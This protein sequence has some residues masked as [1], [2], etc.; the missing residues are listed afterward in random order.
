MYT[1]AQGPPPAP[2][3]NSRGSRRQGIVTDLFIH[4]ISDLS[5]SFADRTAA[6]R[7]RSGRPVS[8]SSP[9]LSAGFDQNGMFMRYVLTLF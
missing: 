2:V 9:G 7:T 1:H 5:S 6:N 3:S 8:N 4:C